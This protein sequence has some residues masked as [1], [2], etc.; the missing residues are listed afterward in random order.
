MEVI[1]LLLAAAGGVAAFALGGLSSKDRAGI[2]LLA[3]VIAAVVIFVMASDSWVLGES[4][5]V[6]AALPLVG[7]LVQH[8]K[9]RARRAQ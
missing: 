1:A 2:A 6:F 5:V 7:A 9:S 3:V 4:W 8:Y